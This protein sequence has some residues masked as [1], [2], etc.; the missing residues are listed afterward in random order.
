MDM[1]C[2]PDVHRDDAALVCGRAFA[3][4]AKSR[5]T[6]GLAP[7]FIDGRGNPGQT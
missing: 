6:S 1:E 5:C 3:G 7:Y 2:G 4:K